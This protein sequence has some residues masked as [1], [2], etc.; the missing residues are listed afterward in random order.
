MKILILGAYGMLGHKLFSILSKNFDVR[1]TCREKKQEFDTYVSPDQLIPG[2]IAENLETVEKALVSFK[3]EIVI[4]CIGVI[5]QRDAAHD[6]IPSIEVNALFPHKLASLAKK[7]NTQ[8]IH[9]S[10]DCVFSGNKGNYMPEDE[11]DARD[12]YGRTKFLGE[13]KEY[14]RCITVRSS[15]IG[16]ELS[17]H[18]G[19]L[20]WFRSQ[21]GKTVRGYKK[22]IWSGFT[23]LQMAK[24]INLVLTKKNLSGL[25]QVAMP[26]PISKYDL[27]VKINEK[28]DLGCIVEPETNTACDRSL[29]GSFFAESTGFVAPDWDEM[30]D[31][32]V[33]DINNSYK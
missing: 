5:K 3:P 23:T 25:A 19:L 11:S 9:F 26:A 8:V 22:A 20:D 21:R 6:P 14:P 12:L 16:P 27:L 29:D 28:M 15:I 13:L 31:E 7:Y 33:T 32:M 18:I 17:H 24:I 1:G 2:V 4:N 10:T 30:L